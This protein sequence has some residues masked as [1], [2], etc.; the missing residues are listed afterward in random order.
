MTGRFAGCDAAQ[1]RQWSPGVPMTRIPNPVLTQRFSDAIAFALVVH[2]A[3]VRKGTSIPYLSHL[4]AV[5]SLVIEQGGS[6]DAAIAVV[7]HDA[8]EDRGGRA[9]LAQIADSA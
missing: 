8:P 5:A 4:L 2:S 6:E 7:L 9:M 3:Q 1:A